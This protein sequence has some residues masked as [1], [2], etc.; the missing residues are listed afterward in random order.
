MEGQELNLFGSGQR[1]MTGSCGYGDE[2]SDTIKDEE[3]LDQLN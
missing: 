3:F 2:P 1:P